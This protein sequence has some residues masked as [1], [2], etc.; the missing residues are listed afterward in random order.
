MKDGER[1]C[2]WMG[3]FFNYEFLYRS[4]QADSLNDVTF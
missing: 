2:I 4:M 3:G 1:E